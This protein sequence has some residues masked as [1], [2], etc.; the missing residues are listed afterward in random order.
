VL[1][2]YWKRGNATGAIASILCGVGTF[3]ALS[4]IKPNMGGIHA[5][6]PTTLASAVAYVVGSL[7][8]GCKRTLK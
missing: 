1:G 7:A 5:I 4:V 8:H 6:V 3:I 2:L